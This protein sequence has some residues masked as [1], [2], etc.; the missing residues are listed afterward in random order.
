[1]ETALKS[2][3]IEIKDD[4]WQNIDVHSIGDKEEVLSEANKYIRKLKRHRNKN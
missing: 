2:L 1:L 4:F 3:N